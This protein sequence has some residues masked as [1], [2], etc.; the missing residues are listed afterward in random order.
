MGALMLRNVAYEHCGNAI[1]FTKLRIILAVN[2][3]DGILEETLANSY[4]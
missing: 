4:T 2:N 1:C 3:I